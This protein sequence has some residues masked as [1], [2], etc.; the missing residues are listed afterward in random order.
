[1][2]PGGDAS[3]AA[4]RKFSYSAYIDLFSG[5][6][7][8][9]VRD[10]GA[11]H[12]SAALQAWRISMK[13]GSPFDKLMV[14]DIDAASV[15]ACETRLRSLGA[16][17]QSFVGPASE[18]VD[19]ILALLPG[20]LHL[21]FADPFNIEHLDFSIIQKLATRKNIDILLHFSVMDVQRNIGQEFDACSS[22]LERAAPGWRQSINL[23]KL[24]VRDRVGA[25]LNY[26]EQRVA[27]LTTLQVADAKP[28]FIN[29][30]R[31]PLY[32]LIHL[33]RHKLAEKLWNDVGRQQRSQLSLFPDED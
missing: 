7:R 1:M 2:F 25:F 11:I 3:R 22:R 15:G 10:T 32:R 30:K 28:L 26:W 20:G 33:S 19:Q 31:G 18:T 13:G 23:A 12:D 29:Q 8:V 24:P 14:A 17:A 5:P 27:S 4:R 9:L 21:A 6:G 16:D